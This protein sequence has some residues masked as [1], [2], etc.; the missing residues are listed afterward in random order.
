MRQVHAYLLPV[1]EQ[2]IED[3]RITHLLKTLDIMEN[4]VRIYVQ[5]Q[6]F[7]KVEIE[8]HE[9]PFIAINGKKKSFDN[10]FEE[11]IGEKELDKD[12]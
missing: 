3:M 11:I 4:D 9:C 6:D 5:G 10:A 1:K 12:F 2:G 8:P 7:K